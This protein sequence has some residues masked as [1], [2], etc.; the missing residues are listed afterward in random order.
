M[1]ISSHEQVRRETLVSTDFSGCQLHT[2]AV[3][4]VWRVLTSVIQ[5]S[6]RKMVVAYQ[7]LY[8]YQHVEQSELNDLVVLFHRLVELKGVIVSHRRL[9]EMVC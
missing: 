5:C 4:H 6:S 1:A 8:L 7:S 2:M 3:A 9:Y